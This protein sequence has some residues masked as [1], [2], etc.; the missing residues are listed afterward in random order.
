[1][2]DIRKGYWYNYI[3]KDLKFHVQT[4]AVINK[5]TRLLGLIENV[6]LICTVYSYQVFQQVLGLS[7][8]QIW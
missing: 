5:A 7:M 6:L 3:N 2:A 4:T 1:M 8:A